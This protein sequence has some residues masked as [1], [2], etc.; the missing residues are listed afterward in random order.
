M[1]NLE[2]LFKTLS[3]LSIDTL[4]RGAILILVGYV[5]I[6]LVLKLLRRALNRTSLDAHIAHTLI[7]A[8]RLVLYFI[9]LTMVMGQLTVC[10]LHQA[11]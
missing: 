9:L 1:T 7:T 5:L 2:P 6:R 4:L 10:S 3:R 11:L 8:C